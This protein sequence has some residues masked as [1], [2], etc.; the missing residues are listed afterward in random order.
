MNH[1]SWEQVVVVVGQL[2]VPHLRL[3]RGGKEMRN[4]MVSNLQMEELGQQ[5]E[6]QEMMA[7][8]Q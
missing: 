1:F 4:S 2:V 8:G 7:M 3:E 6:R 5:K